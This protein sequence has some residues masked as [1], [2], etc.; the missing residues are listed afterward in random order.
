MTGPAGG[1]EVGATGPEVTYGPL[2]RTDIVRYA[3]ASN[4][5][6]PM[7]H[8]DEFAHAAGQPSVI[9]HGMLSAGPLA[10][11]LTAWFGPD[12][13]VRYRVRFRERVF[14]GDTLTARGQVTRINQQPEGG[15]RAEI[16]LTLVRQTG[17]AAVTGTATV[18]VSN[19]SAAR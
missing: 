7:H 8:D 19:Q 14:P 2:S 18:A 13:V 4:D 12:S 17:A 10:S 16:A 9:A 1:L 3:G 5:F 6:N 11:F 15:M